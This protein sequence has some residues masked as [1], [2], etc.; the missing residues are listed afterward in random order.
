[1]NKHYNTMKQTILTLTLLATVQLVFAQERLPREEALTYAAAVSADAK[2]LKGTPIATDVD[3]QQPV[4]LRDGDY[5]GMVL[6]E[7]KLS[8]EALA[9]A[10]QKVLPIGQLW[11]HK[12]T[13][14]RDGEAIEADKLRL[15]AVNLNG[16]SVTVPQCALGVRRNSAGTLELLVFGKSKEPLL[17]T[18][19]KSAEA[20]QQV[21][22][23]L[24]AQREPASAQVTL[25]ILGKYQATLS[26]T[27]MLF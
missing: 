6:P 10:D 14:M 13:P 12:L 16:E 1:M 19:L 4:A 9:K 17:A 11:L 21:P 15:V 22:I 20:A 18:A 23:D 27:E 2:Q 5:G 8:A 26:V 25:K 3:V 7:K 24:E